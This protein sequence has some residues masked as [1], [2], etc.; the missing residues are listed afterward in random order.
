MYVVF[1][2]FLFLNVYGI[3]SWYGWREV[4]EDK[5]VELFVLWII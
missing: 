5:V 1:N 2:F 3:I 4:K